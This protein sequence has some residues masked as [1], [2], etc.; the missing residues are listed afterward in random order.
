MVV[1]AVLAAIHSAV[2][3]AMVA[4][5]VPVVTAVMAPTVS[6]PVR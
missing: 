3:P 5:R 2:R 4:L 6:Q 1:R